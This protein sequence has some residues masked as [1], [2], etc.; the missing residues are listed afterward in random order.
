MTTLT[1]DGLLV[2]ADLLGVQTLPGVLGVGPQ[3]DSEAA[4]R[5][6]QDLARAELRRAGLVDGYDDVRGELADALHV[7]ARPERELIARSYGQTES[8][9]MCLARNGSA[10]AVATRV[11]TAFDVRTTW[12]DDSGAALAKPVLDM[13]GPCPAAAIGDFSAPAAE[14]RP[15]LDA[16]TDAAG[17]AQVA[18][19][20]GV[21]D[22]EAMEFGLA[23]ASCRV[24]TEVVAYAHAEGAGTRSTGAVAIY[25]TERGRIVASPG[26]S[27]DLT[28]W[29][30]FTPG[31][32]HRIAQAISA[33]IDTLPGG[34][35]MP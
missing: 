34:R 31:S 11:G 10:H 21:D 14:L 17:F 20:L 5:A 16:A 6:A 1:N 8:R 2:A 18:L 29:S 23:M 28:I 12:A 19:T 35:W 33:L 24:R 22:R 26:S 27:A 15:R 25:D 32:D 9:R 30:T 7:L 13:L 3:Q 4:W